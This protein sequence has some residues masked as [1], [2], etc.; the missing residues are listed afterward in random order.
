MAP[1]AVECAKPCEGKRHG[2][3][4]CGVMAARGYWGSFMGRKPKVG[5]PQVKINDVCRWQSNTGG[6]Q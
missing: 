6:N 4:S 2:T 3:N 1:L 5:E